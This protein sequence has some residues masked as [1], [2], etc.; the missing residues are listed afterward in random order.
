[1]SDVEL[2]DTVALLRDLPEFGL[3]RGQVGAVMDDA[4]GDCVLVEFADFEGRSVS[5][6]TIRRADLLRLKGALVAVE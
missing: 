2:L 5:L 4:G 1:M 6:P 3:V